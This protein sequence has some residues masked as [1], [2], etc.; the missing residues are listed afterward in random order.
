VSA[1]PFREGVGTGCLIALGL[2]GFLLLLG[3]FA[4]WSGT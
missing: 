3:K 4:Q 2:F 1:S